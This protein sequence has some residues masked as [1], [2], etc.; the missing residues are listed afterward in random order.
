MSIILILLTLIYLRKSYKYSFNPN[1]NEFEVYGKLVYSLTKK[2]VNPTSSSF[3][4]FITFIFFLI[5]NVFGMIP[6][7]LLYIFITLYASIGII[8]DILVGVLII[9]AIAINITLLIVHYY[10]I[11]YV[12][13]N[14]DEIWYLTKIINMKKMYMIHIIF[15]YYVM[16]FGLCYCCLGL[17]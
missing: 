14:Y 8:S 7:G 16:A 10:A 15:Y 13:N 1:Y 11:K 2:L 5:L 4:L 6:Y 12:Y 17:F 3:R 9:S